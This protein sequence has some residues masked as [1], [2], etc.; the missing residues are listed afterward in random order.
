M[1]I[2]SRSIFSPDCCIWN[3][4][5][6]LSSSND[7]CQSFKGDECGW[8]SG[9]I[10]PN[11]SFFN[12]LFCRK[13][14]YGRV[15]DRLR[16]MEHGFDNFANVVLRNCSLLLP[17]NPRKVTFGENVRL[18]TV[19]HGSFNGDAREPTGCFRSEASGRYKLDCTIAP[20]MT[21]PTIA[22]TNRLRSNR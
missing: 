4:N 14:D 22:I 7:L 17:A 1:G 21:Q 10:R 20:M 11:V 3:Y 13:L 9:S 5:D 18:G 19:F 16:H 2:A 15:F 6:G 12:P 8:L